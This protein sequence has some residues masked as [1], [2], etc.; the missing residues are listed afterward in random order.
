MFGKILYITEN[1]AHIENVKTGEQ[2]ADLM[3]MYVVFEAPDQAI[4]GEVQEVNE[5][6][7]FIRFLGEFVNKKYLSGVIRKPV[8]SSTIRIINDEELKELV[9]TYNDTSF[10]IGQS[11]IYKDYTVCVNINNLLSNHM[12]IF[13]NSGSGKSCGVARIVQNI[14]GNTNLFSYNANIFIFDAYGEYKTAFTRL[15]EYNSNYCYKFITTMPSDADDFLLKVPFHLLNLDDLT[16]LLQ[17][18][19]HSQLPIIERSL[20]LTKI[21]SKGD[22]TAAKYKNHLIAKALMAILYSNQ[23]TANKKNEIFKILEV[24]HTPEFDFDTTIQGLG[25]TRNFSECLEIDSNGNF[26]ESVLITNYILGFVNEDL[27]MTEEPADAYYIMK[28]FAKAMEFTLI[29]EGFQNN[30]QLYGDAILLKVRIDTILNSVVAKIYEYDKYITVNDYI[31]NLIIKN[32]AKAQVININLEDIDDVHAKVTVKI[33]SRM[34][35]GFVKKSKERASMPIHIFLEEAHRYVQN[36]SDTF[37]IGYNIFDRIAK[38]G[39]K[40]GIL[41]NI[42]SQ[43]PVDISDTVISQCSN[44]LIFKMTHP[45]DIDYIQKMLPNISE[46]VVEKQKILQPG[47]CV[48]FGSAFKLPM[49]IKMELPNPMPYSTNCDVN[50]RWRGPDGLKGVVPTVPVNQPTSEGAMLNNQ[51]ITQ[52][53]DLGIILP[54]PNAQVVVA[55]Q[56]PAVAV[57]TPTNDVPLMQSEPLDVI[58]NVPVMAPIEDQTLVKN[59]FINNSDIASSNST[60]S[61]KGTSINDFLMAGPEEIKNNTQTYT[62]EPVE[63]QGQ[64][65][66]FTQSVPPLVNPVT[67]EPQAIP[68]LQDIN[69]Q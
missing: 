67:N 51:G 46:D 32:G 15:N 36:D 33:I 3:N 11:A 31:T 54:N 44:F 10:K 37:L 24:C 56:V 62:S 66:T 26:G 35:F 49:I 7:I 9:G 63:I 43:R 50:K 28:D 27:E 48:A 58:N 61:Q 5:K 2:I 41:L 8:L 13:G 68:P 42:I 59:K 14:F 60:T 45:R 19:S 17:A 6:E 22:E 38:E 25:Y 12:A 34:L 65:M 53:P 47:N 30:E 64:T 39:R 23:I 69:N 1:I 40:Y 52:K 57:N 20:K 29:S 21:F 16:L 18:D 4:L 55:N